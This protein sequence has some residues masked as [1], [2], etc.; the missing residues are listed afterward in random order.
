MATA[1]KLGGHFCRICGQR[2][3]NEKFSG[4]GHAA[5]I[6]KECAKLSATERNELEALT[7]IDRIAGEY[8][9]SRENLNWLS[10]K[11]KDSRYPESAERA[12]A[13]IDARNEQVAELRE[14]ARRDLS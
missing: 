13:V 2:K 11:A 10:K 9:I 3:A 1:K 8:S 4:R 5:H 14:F 12:K 7:K 6:C